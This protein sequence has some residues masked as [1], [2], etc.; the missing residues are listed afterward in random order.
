MSKLFGAIHAR[1]YDSDLPIRDIYVGGK[2]QSANGPL[3]TYQIPPGEVERFRTHP[4]PQE[5]WDKYRVTS[6]S[7]QPS[8]M[9]T[10]RNFKQ[11][12]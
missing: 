10:W 9:D 2:R 6:K 11:H 12:D 4:P 8:R 7:I 1:N 5:E 3:I